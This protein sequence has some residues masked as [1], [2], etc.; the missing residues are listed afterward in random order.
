MRSMRTHTHL[1]QGMMDSCRTLFM[2]RSITVCHGDFGRICY[3]EINRVRVLHATRA[4]QLYFLISGDDVV[5]KVNEKPV[6]LS[7]DRAVALDSFSAFEIP[8]IESG[9]PAKVLSVYVDPMWFATHCANGDSN[10]LRFGVQSFQV[11]AEISHHIGHIL[12]LVQPPAPTKE[13]GYSSALET[14]LRHLCNTCFVNPH[15]R[16]DPSVIAVNPLTT[17]DSRIRKSISIMNNH[18]RG[19]LCLDEIAR[20]AGLSRPHFYR[21]FRDNLGFT[22]NIYMNLLRMEFAIERLSYSN[23]PVT[24]I[25]LDLGFASQASFTRFF[26]AN[27]G[28]PPTDYRRLVNVPQPNPIGIAPIVEP[29]RAY[30]SISGDAL[31]EAPPARTA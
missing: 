1:V 11:S 4:G 30:S 19:D 7:T 27:Q 3:T 13:P 16:Y 10:W 14:R 28:V 26:G 2:S 25:A 17:C 12:S 15:E 9:E 21:L 31:L 23:Q 5:L 24:S 18:V 8:A 6:V 20:A 29:A 22:P